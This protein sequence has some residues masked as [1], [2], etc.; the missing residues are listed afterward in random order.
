MVDDL[1]DGIRDLRANAV[2]RDE[3]DPML[4]A[5]PRRLHVRH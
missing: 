1:H 4:L 5:Y 2:A 3:G